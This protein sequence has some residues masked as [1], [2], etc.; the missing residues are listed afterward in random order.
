MDIL[1]R[2]GVSRILRRDGIS[3]LLLAYVLYYSHLLRRDGISSVF[4]RDGASRIRLR[5]LTY[6]PAVF[7]EFALSG[8]SLLEFVGTTTFIDMIESGDPNVRLSYSAEIHLRSL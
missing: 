2:D 8:D 7:G 4:Q 5:L 6:S 1:R 3:H